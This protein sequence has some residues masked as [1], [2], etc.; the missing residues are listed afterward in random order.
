[1]PSATCPSRTCWRTSSAWFG[2]S[3]PSTKG[4][5]VQR[6]VE[7]GRLGARRS[8][9]PPVRSARFVSGRRGQ[10]PLRHSD[11]TMGSTNT[12]P[13]P[14]MIEA[15][16]RRFLPASP[17]LGRSPV[18]TTPMKGCVED[19]ALFGGA[20]AFETTLHV[21]R[22]NVG[23]RDRLFEPLERS[24]RPALALKRWPLRSRARDHLGVANRVSATLLRWPMAPSG[25]TSRFG[26]QV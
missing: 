20:P 11:T 25:S 5:R 12:R 23:H 4:S 10:P 1:M 8:L 2:A 15:D 17:R 18:P 14:T 16:R 6:D 3:S 26:P 24:A 9:S 7:A 19:L 13:M 22:P 21:G